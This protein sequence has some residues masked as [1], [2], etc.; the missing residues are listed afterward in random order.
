MCIIANGLFSSHKETVRGG[1]QLVSLTIATTLTLWDSYGSIYPLDD[2]MSWWVPYPFMYLFI[3][4]CFTN[5]LKIPILMGWETWLDEWKNYLYT[6]I[7]HKRNCFFLK[8]YFWKKIILFNFSLYKINFFIFS[9][10][11]YMIIS[12]IFL[13]NKKLLF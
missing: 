12:K 4:F 2:K 7:I 6:K 10:Q 9:Y 5:E 11:F 3:Y 8:K 13:K 1:Y